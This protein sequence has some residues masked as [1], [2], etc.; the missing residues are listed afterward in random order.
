M[1]ERDYPSGLDLIHPDWVGGM[2]M[3]FRRSVF[4]SLHGFDERYY[5][6]YEDV[7]ICAR[8]KLSNLQTVLCSSSPIVHHAQRSS[9]SNI[10]YLRWHLLSMLRFFSSPV[11]RQL[12]GSGWL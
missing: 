5:L 4:E 7:D 11:Y 3:L 2:F 12:R 9:H 10:R 6:C 8:L 1:T